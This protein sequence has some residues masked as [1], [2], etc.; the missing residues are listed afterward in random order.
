[1]FRISLIFR[2]CTFV[3]V[4]STPQVHGA[5]QPYY[6]RSQLSTPVVFYTQPPRSFEST[7]TP[8]A[9]GHNSP[10]KGIL[11]SSAS[12]GSV[13]SGVSAGGNS[14]LSNSSAVTQSSTATGNKGMSKTKKEIV[15]AVINGQQMIQ[16]EK[17]N[18]YC[19]SH[20]FSDSYL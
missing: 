8:A 3:L 2:I 9:T 20:G 16:I 1:M 13:G 5:D 10:K 18:N 12:V 19:Q 6:E 17:L 14:V 7:A 4:P 15:S 11:S